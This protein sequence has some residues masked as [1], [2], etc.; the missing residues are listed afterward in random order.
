MAQIS[1]KTYFTRLL[2]FTLFAGVVVFLWNN[3]SSPRFQTTLGWVILFF[4]IIVT[5]GIHFFLTKS[6]NQE[7]KKF[8]FKY[9]MISGLKL[10]GF[11]T[12]ILVYALLK[13]EAALGFTLLFLTLYL[14]FSA[15]EAIILLNYFKK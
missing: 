8:V 3:Y 12:I 4:F 6:A 7:P 15:F 1:S 2:L 14:F 5:A 13:R 11:L 9:M 10:F